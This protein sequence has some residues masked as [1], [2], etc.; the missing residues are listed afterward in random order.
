[1]NTDGCPAPTGRIRFRQYRLDDI[2][3]V[4]EMFDDTEA[5]RWYPTHREPGQAQRWIEW[6]LDNYTTD[7]HGLWV[8]EDPTTKT[9]LG[10]CGLTYQLVEDEQLLEIGYHLQHRHRRHGYATEAAQACHAYAL[11]ELDANLVC[12]IVDPRNIASIAVA[13]RIHNSTRSFLT[14]TG[15][16]MNLYWT[17]RPQTHT[18]SREPQQRG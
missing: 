2:Q 14:Q 13:R 18:T 10:D 7:G 12:S 17:K 15:T 4:V 8:I 16:T 9:F 11:D 6:N 1:M 3:A 5:R